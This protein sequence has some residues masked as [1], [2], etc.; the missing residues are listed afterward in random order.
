[1]TGGMRLGLGGNLPAMSTAFRE[2]MLHNAPELPFHR[3]GSQQS[4]SLQ[5]YHPTKLPKLCPAL[6]RD[7]SACEVC[8]QGLENSISNERCGRERYQ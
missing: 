8:S 2:Q 1:M 3:I 6:S 4:N 7:T 5:K